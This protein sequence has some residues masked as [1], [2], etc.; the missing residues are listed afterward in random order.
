MPRDA[1]DAFDVRDRDLTKSISPRL[2]AGMRANQ[3]SQAHALAETDER[4]M[5]TDVLMRPGVLRRRLE[6][7]KELRLYTKPNPEAGIREVIKQS[8]RISVQFHERAYRSDGGGRKATGRWVP[9]SDINDHNGKRGATYFDRVLRVEKDDGDR[10]AIETPEDRRSAKAMEAKEAKDRNT[11]VARL[12]RYDMLLLANAYGLPLWVLEVESDDL[13]ED[14][15][16]IEAD[17]RAS[18]DE[19]KPLLME[20]TAKRFFL[21]AAEN[22]FLAAAERPPSPLLVFTSIEEAARK[23]HRA[24]RQELGYPDEAP[25][26]TAGAQGPSIGYKSGPVITN[27]EP[28][29]DAGAEF[30]NLMEIADWKPGEPVECLL[31]LVDGDGDV[32]LLSNQEITGGDVL[33]RD[34]FQNPRVPHRAWTLQ[35]GRSQLLLVMARYEADLN[36]RLDRAACFQATKG[37]AEGEAPMV[38]EDQFDDLRRRLLRRPDENWKIY[39]KPLKVREPA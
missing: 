23:G 4:Y 5:T 33:H 24:A 21:L 10:S 20:I 22:Y 9:L 3:A 30:W 38:T 19:S 37:L 18:D 28:A 13:F 11:G 35:P 26:N 6:K 34:T 2:V 39:A 16:T 12:P 25:E 17:A 36:M 31:F 15:V 7:L 1:D 14:L 8:A 32:Y 29:I 27:T